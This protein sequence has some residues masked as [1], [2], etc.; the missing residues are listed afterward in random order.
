VQAR[1]GESIVPGVDR[2]VARGDSTGYVA[3]RGRRGIIAQ[4]ARDG[5]EFLTPF[6][7]R[8]GFGMTG[9]GGLPW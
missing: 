7:K 9:F 6:K 4:R 5:E 3:S 8:T 1:K 2:V